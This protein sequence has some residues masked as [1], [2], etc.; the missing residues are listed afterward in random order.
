VLFLDRASF[1][2]ATQNVRGG[3]PVLFPF[4]GKLEGD[5]LRA[6]GTKMKQHGFGRREAWSAATRH[7]D[8][9]SVRLAASDATRAAYPFEF[10]AEQT[11]LALARGLHVELLVTNLGP[12]PMPLSPG[13]H[14]YFAC[15]AAKKASLRTDVESVSRD[16]VGD[17]REFDFGVAAPSN[18]RAR[19]DVPGVGPIQLSFSPEMR[20]LQLWSLPGKDFVCLEPFFG[21]PG[22]I[23]TDRRLDL[24][25]GSSRALWMRIEL[26][27]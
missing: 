23:D 3:I 8:S 12:Q 21:P 7:A 1:E 20:H 11:C 6:T 13:W 2:D 24:G 27:D 4:A 22:T 25:P 5:T 16:R 17:D 10:V 14:P 19:F 26:L 18:G 15:P 9:L